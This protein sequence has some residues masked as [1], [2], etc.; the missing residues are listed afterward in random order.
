MILQYSIF[1]KYDTYKILLLVVSIFFMFNLFPLTLTAQFVLLQLIPR[2]R[3]AMTFFTKC[4]HPVHSLQTSLRLMPYVVT[5]G[6]YTPIHT[7]TDIC[8][9]THISTYTYTL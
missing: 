9:H 5:G 3:W 6:V 4:I 1:M 2:G 7:H 8:M